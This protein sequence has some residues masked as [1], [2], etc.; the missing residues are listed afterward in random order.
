MPGINE[1]SQAW[2]GHA[3]MA[4]AAHYSDW[5]LCIGDPQG[6][7]H[8]QCIRLAEQLDPKA[9]AVF[10]RCIGAQS[11]VS[12]QPARRATVDSTHHALNGGGIELEDRLSQ[13]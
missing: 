3:A 4:P 10:K 12:C 6:L 1:G 11:R 5:R 9:Q 2:V 13:L 8:D 7:Q